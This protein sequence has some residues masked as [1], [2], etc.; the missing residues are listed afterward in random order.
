MKIKNTMILEK[1]IQKNDLYYSPKDV[2]DILGL[3]GLDN[4][5]SRNIQ[6]KGRK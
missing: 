6:K 3:P 4:K 1:K 5:S 2:E